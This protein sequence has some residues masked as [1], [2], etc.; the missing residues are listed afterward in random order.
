MPLL[1]ALRRQ[2]QE[3][4]LVQGQPKL[5]EFQDSQGHTEKL[6][7][8]GKKKKRKEKKSYSSVYFKYWWKDNFVAPK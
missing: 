3:D 8:R 4:L 5:S 7:R 6:S 2:R 1:P